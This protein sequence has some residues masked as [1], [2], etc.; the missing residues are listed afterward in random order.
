[1]LRFLLS[2]PLG[3]AV[4][5][6]VACT[7]S[8]IAFRH[9]PVS[10]LPSLDVPHMT[11]SVKFP[12]GTPEDV[13]TNVLKP[14]RETLLTLNGLKKVESIAQNES[15]K[16]TLMFEYGTPMNLAY[17]DANEKIDQL[18]TALPRSLGRPIVVRA[19]TA[20]IPIARIQVV[21]K[22]DANLLVASDLTSK[23]LRRRLEQL[24]GVGLVDVNGWQQRVVRVEPRRQELHRF[25]LNEETIVQ[26]IVDA[27]LDLGSIS[28]KDGNYRYY[29]KIDNRMG[30]PDRLLD[31]P[32]S[33]P[34]RMGTLPLRQFARVYIEPD[35][36]TGYHLF[37]GQPALVMTVH[38]Q[39]SARMPDLMPLL[40]ETVSAFRQTYEEY[41]FELTQDQS[42]LLTLS[43]DN[44]SQA[45]LW[46]GLF[47]FGV[48]FL[49]MRGW[50]E[51]L[52]MGVVLPL[53]LL[54]TFSLFYVFGLSLNVLSLSG[55]ALGL[56]MLVDNSIVVID[57][58]AL[59]QQEGLSLRESCV[60]G[61]A[62]VMAP[63]V[64]SALTNLV[65]FLPLIFLSGITGALFFD[66]AVAVAC[67]LSISLVCTFIAVPML[68]LGLH[69]N[70]SYTPSRQSAVFNLLQRVYETVFEWIWDRRRLSFWVISL[71][72]PLAIGLF[73]FLP[74]QG[75]PEIE[76]NEIRLLIDWDEPID[77]DTNRDRVLDI[78][79]Q[80]KD[81]YHVMEAEVGFQ[82]F[83]LSSEVKSPQQAD[84]Y[85]LLAEGVDRERTLGEWQTYFQNQF[86]KATVQFENAPNAF[87]QLFSSTTP[88]L[89]A[90]I[91]DPRSKKP[92]PP[93][94]ADSLFRDLQDSLTFSRAKGF[95]T[96]VMALIMIDIEKAARVNVTAAQITRKLKQLLGNY[97]VSEFSD[98]GET[99]QIKL[100]PDERNI[101]EILNSTW[102]QTTQGTSFP[103]RELATIRLYQGYRYITADA[104]GPYQAITISEKG[105]EEDTLEWLQRKLAG[106]GLAVDSV[107]EW[108]DNRKNLQDILYLLLISVFL[109]F[110]ILTA[111]F[112]SVRQPFFVI[113]TL[114]LG[115]AGSLIL[116]AITGGTINIMSGIGLIVVLGVIDN[117]AILKLDRINRLKKT[118][119]VEDA[120]RQAGI[121]RLKPIVMNTFTNVLA[122]VPIV[123]ATGL[124][125]D[126]QRPVGITTIGG[127]LVGTFTALF[128]IPL[129]YGYAYG[130]VNRTARA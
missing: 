111:E 46:G 41:D 63:L 76:R 66:Q 73:V 4:V 53:S 43:I 51:P 13:E 108:F 44:L 65:V 59:K 109:M 37:N 12:G 9:L 114:P 113:L 112:E 5:F 110:V 86:P 69:K 78:G 82:Q 96:E 68:F 38:K 99:V 49:F 57:S 119:P 85:F 130:R 34:D 25:G 19:S 11:V 10:L 17:I 127:L 36:S 90:R 29:L 94:T 22:R 105:A 47:A 16:V 67:I 80:F 106:H 93:A 64:G 118:M 98:F 100:K 42:K 97:L 2:R 14:V 62:E 21:P 15:G 126:L 60:S 91:R 55:L 20:D 122:L 125:A 32:I 56:G 87:E 61:T 33:L 6:F 3:V 115:L 24:E 88:W 8:V 23:V 120:I 1:M 123:F 52:V 54:L 28:I 40:Y 84:I 103:L 116:L 77:V 58:I 7:L 89:E 48:L 81:S 74:K 79:N 101:G 50:R 124:G 26:H 121:Q 70:R 102:I 117:D 129:L 107:G 75:F 92:L 35:A 95:D 128:Y 30:D 45:L 39:A 72:I 104:S 71:L 31:I 18:L 27:K 83:L